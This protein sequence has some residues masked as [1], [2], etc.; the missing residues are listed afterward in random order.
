MHTF[1]QLTCSTLWGEL[2]WM[3]AIFFEGN[4]MVR[5][6][7][8]GGK[9]SLGE[10]VQSTIFH[11]GNYPPGQLFEGQLSREQLPGEKFSSG[12]IVLEPPLL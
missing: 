1:P 6:L 11:G 4:F 10:I 3:R 7:L 8:S 2:A 12:A 9:F 5:E